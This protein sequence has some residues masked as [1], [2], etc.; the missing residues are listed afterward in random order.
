MHTR[1]LLNF[2]TWAGA[3]CLI[4]SLGATAAAKNNLNCTFVDETGKP[5]AKQEF[6]LTAVNGGKE[7]KRRANDQGLAEFKG[8]DDGSYHVRPG[9]DIQGYV[10]HKSPPIQLSGN[11]TQTCTHKLLSVNYANGLLQE[12]LTLTQ[13][14]KLA[15]AEE[16]GKRAIDLMPEESGAHYVLAVAYATGGKEADAVT[17]IQKAAEIAPDKY[18]DKVQMVRLSAISAQADQLMAKNDLEGAL[19][20]YQDMLAVAPNEP[21]AHYNM[22]IAYGRASKF[23]EALKAIDKAI[24]LK[25]GDLE[26]GQMKIRLQDMYLKSLDQKLEVP[27]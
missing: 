9:D 19:K 3:V 27:R 20:K 16:R 12:V 2:F 11:Q 24:A 8:L 6:V 14:K 22:A 26:M 23:D 17:A 1:G 18:G 4:G 15:E 25:P 10:I 21:V 7:T 5:L 13:Q